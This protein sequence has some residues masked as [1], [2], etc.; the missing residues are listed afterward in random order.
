MNNH[1]THS[2]IKNFAEM[3]VNLPKDAAQKHRDQVNNLRERLKKHIEENPGFAL[4]KMLHAGSVAKGTALKTV[5]DL[6]AAVYVRS[7]DAPGDDSDLVPW[8][9][10]RVREANPNLAYD[11]IVENKH[12]VTIS[13]RGSGLDVDVVPVLY[14]DEDED[15]GH[16]VDKSTGARMLTSIP[17]HLD[18]IRTRK[19]DHRTHFAQVVR[20]A[21]WWVKEQKAGDPN[22]KCKSFMV[23]LVLAHLADQGDI[24]LADY[25]EALAGFFAY[26]VKSGLTERIAFM[27]YYTESALPPP[28]GAAIEVF[29]PV[30]PDNNITVRYSDADRQRLVEAA[31]DAGDAIDEALFADTKTRAVERW[32]LVLGSSF[33]P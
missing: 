22:F 25:G 30:N 28:T 4:V 3:R 6:D 1:V 31:A 9:A 19:N 23:E 18:F 16:L 29:D 15:K 14:E 2:D 17:L 20:L 24:D 13:F 11:Q 27:D 10:E 8:L 5:N 7:D 26:I 21:K 33:R 32:Q 12:C